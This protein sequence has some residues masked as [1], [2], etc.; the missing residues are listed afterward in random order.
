M[1][2]KPKNVFWVE[3]NRREQWDREYEKR[4]S[5]AK[6]SMRVSLVGTGDAKTSLAR[7]EKEKAGEELARGEWDLRQMSSHKVQ[8]FAAKG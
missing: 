7:L 6:K 4:V 1:E 2:P 5:A 8:L 3:M